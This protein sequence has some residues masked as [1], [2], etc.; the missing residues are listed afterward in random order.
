MTESDAA[1][2]FFATPFEV[3]GKRPPLDAPFD[4]RSKSAIFV[5]GLHRSGTSLIQRVLQS[6]P[7]VTGFRET[8]AP[9]DEGQH[10]QTIYP[11][12][13]LFGGAGK[14]AF[15]PRARLTE[16]SELIT[17][18][19]RDRIC[20]EW[21]AYLDLTK[22]WFVEKSPPNLLRMRFLRELFPRSTFV[23]VVR[24]PLVVALATKKWSKTSLSELIYHWV[25]AHDIFR[26]DSEHLD[27][28]VLA[29]YEDMVASPERFFDGLW[30]QLGLAGAA[31]TE[32]VS[33]RNQRY[34]D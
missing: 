23:C 26:R 2:Q 6:H 29:R 27:G 33:D 1:P 15:D 34:L 16:S 18:E 24:H 12:A 32:S 14:F 28:V 3:S 17:P 11:V 8:G 31:L 13:A 30:Q 20:R 25:V 9:Q 19:S 7:D 10:L 5:C 22:P 4:H 21:G